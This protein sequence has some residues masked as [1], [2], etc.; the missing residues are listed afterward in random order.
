ME[1]FYDLNL[2]PLFTCIFASSSDLELCLFPTDIYLRAVGGRAPVFSGQTIKGLPAK[3]DWRDKG[4]V[5]PVQN[6]LAVRLMHIDEIYI[7]LGHI[8]EIAV[9]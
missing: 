5:A 8:T 7:L 1:L 9:R 2:Q 3:F 4:M 6:Q